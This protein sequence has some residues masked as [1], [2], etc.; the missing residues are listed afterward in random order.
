MPACTRENETS[1][2]VRPSSAACPRPAYEADAPLLRRLLVRVA[3]RTQGSASRVRWAASGRGRSGLNPAYSGASAVRHKCSFQW[4]GSNTAR[5]FVPPRRPKKS[6]H[7][8]LLIMRSP[9]R[10]NPAPQMDAAHVVQP[11][12]RPF[13]YRTCVNIAPQAVFVG[14]LAVSCRLIEA[15]VASRHGGLTNVEDPQ[16]TSSRTSMS[17]GLGRLGPQNRSKVAFPE[18]CLCFTWRPKY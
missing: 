13:R 18:R 4:S 9:K 8:F 15:Y 5:P 14:T 17:K 6:E 11:P 1:R 10:W 3:S 12:P 7:T 2:W 16:G